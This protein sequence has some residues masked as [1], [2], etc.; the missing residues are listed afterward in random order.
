M[1]PKHFRTP[2]VLAVPLPSFR[3]AA[4]PIPTFLGAALNTASLLSASRRRADKTQVHT[5]VPSVK[6]RPWQTAMVAA[7]PKGTK[8]VKKKRRGSAESDKTAAQAFC[9]ILAVHRESFLNVTQ[10]LQRHH[11]STSYK[12]F[13][14]SLQLQK[15]SENLA[16]AS[17]SGYWLDSPLDH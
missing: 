8:D 9:F 7:R 4:L 12:Y 6:H 1:T 15:T 14:C 5:P 16:P 13:H 17:A 3:P 2:S 11:D 10:A